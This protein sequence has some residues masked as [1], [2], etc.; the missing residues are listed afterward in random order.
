MVWGWAQ[1]AR[2]G[3]RRGASVTHSRLAVVFLAEN[4]H[5][6]AVDSLKLSVTQPTQPEDLS[7]PCA[8]FDDCEGMITS[9]DVSWP[10][11]PASWIPAVQLTMETFEA[12]SLAVE[13]LTVTPASV[14]I[15]SGRRLGLGRRSLTPG[16]KR[17]PSASS[18]T[19]CIFA[20]KLEPPKNP[21]CPLSEMP[22]AVVRRKNRKSSWPRQ[23]PSM[24]S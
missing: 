11:A 15:S 13:A 4:T 9:M 7:I 14:T 20:R 17:R 8:C 19:F 12:H 16:R 1:Y 6:L 18:R 24:T 10:Q 5:G 21:F 2:A 22:S 23:N 3:P